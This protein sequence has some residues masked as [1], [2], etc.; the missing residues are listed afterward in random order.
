[1]CKWVT[2]GSGKVEELM[3]KEGEGC[4]RQCSDMCLNSMTQDLGCDFDCNVAERAISTD[5]KS[6]K[7]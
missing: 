1:M 7:E 3:S 6:A 2:Q 4:A 5:G